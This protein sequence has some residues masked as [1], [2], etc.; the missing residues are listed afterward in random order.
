MTFSNG[1]ASFPITFATAG[2]QSLTLTDSSNSMVGTASTTVVTATAPV[3]IPTPATIAAAAA[4]L[5]LML[6]ST[7]VPSGVTVMIQAVA[8]DNNNNPVPTYNGTATVSCTETGTGTTFPATVTFQ[9]GH[10]SIPVT[11]DS[12]SPQTITLTDATNDISGSLQVTVVSDPTPTPGPI[13]PIP[14]PPT[15]APP[16]AQQQIAIMLPP[17]APEGVQI[18]VNAVAVGATATGASSYS[19]TAT[20]TCT[21]PNATFPATVT[22]TN[23]QASFPVTFATAGPQSLTLTDSTNSMVGTGSTMVVS[24]IPTPPPVAA[25]AKFVLQ[26]PPPPAGSSTTAPA[27]TVPENTLIPITAQA[28]DPNGNP[29]GFN[30]TATLTI[31]GGTASFGGSQT[32]IVQSVDVTFVNGQAQLPLTFTSVTQQGSPPDVLTLTDDLNPAVTGTLTVA[33]LPPLSSTGS[34]SPT[35]T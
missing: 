18:N 19:G 2:P 12:T 25:P 9:N 34:S 30:G 1:Q 21:D 32:P 22:F 24:P 6:P 7:T 16:V 13:G 27:G 31:T 5:V 4:Q 10:A 20:I 33:V 26:L 14:V 35:S 17:M 8:E 15:P 3:P 29:V 11:F 23:G 28:L